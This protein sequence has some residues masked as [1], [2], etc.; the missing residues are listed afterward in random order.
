MFL[1]TFLPRDPLEAAS[2]CLPSRRNGESGDPKDQ[3][4]FIIKSEYYLDPLDLLIEQL[5]VPPVPLVC[6]T[7]NIFYFPFYLFMKIFLVIL[8]DCII[9]LQ[10]VN[11]MSII[12]IYHEDAI[13]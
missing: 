12:N 6:Q 11:L 4:R 9:C 13:T 10:S 7:E 5:T 1:Q 2:L 8:T 3:H